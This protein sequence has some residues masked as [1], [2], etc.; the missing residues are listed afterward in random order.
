MSLRPSDG[1][2]EVASYMG[3][4]REEVDGEFARRRTPARGGQS[5]RLRVDVSKWTAWH[6]PGPFRHGLTSKTGRVVSVYGL[7]NR[8]RH[9]TSA[10]AQ[11]A[12]W[13]RVAPFI[14]SWLN[15]VF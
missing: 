11:V 5:C 10:W 15:F 12:Q 13:T 14:P 2:E 7:S 8:P 6:G 4:A 9:D 1:K 3:R